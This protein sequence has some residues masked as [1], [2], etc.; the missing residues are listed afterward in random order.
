MDVY[1]QN[2]VC[3][4][5]VWQDKKGKEN[6][7]IRIIYL[8]GMIKIAKVYCRDCVLQSSSC[9]A[10]RTVDRKQ[11]GMFQTMKKIR[12]LWT[13]ALVRRYK[14]RQT[15]KTHTHTQA[16]ITFLDL[17]S[18]CGLIKLYLSLSLSLHNFMRWAWRMCLK[19]LHGSRLRTQCY[20]NI[21]TYTNRVTPKAMTHIRTYEIQHLT[22]HPS[23]YYRYGAG[24]SLKVNLY[25]TC[26]HNLQWMKI[27]L[28]EQIS[29]FCWNKGLMIQCIA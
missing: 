17:P 26:I 11:E 27:N 4:V 5:L 29:W 25:L 3:F 12:E 8:S 9:E 6:N 15:H 28:N 23:L 13:S 20:T 7:H 16:H 1:L 2:F 22:N 10:L 14:D 24:L 21:Y 18:D 19:M